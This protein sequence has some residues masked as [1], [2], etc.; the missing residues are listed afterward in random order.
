M[1]GGFQK[2]LMCV[3]GGLGDMVWAQWDELR[4]AAAV[5]GTILYIC[6]QP[7]YWVRTVRGAF[8]R[9]VVAIGVESVVLVCGMAF[10]VGIT[11]VAQLEF[12]VAEA[13]QSQMLGS[14][15]VAVV[16]R[17][18]SPVLIGIIV[19]V[20]SGSTMATELG[21]MKIGGQ[22]HVL[23]AQGISPF[24]Y[25]VV[26]RVLAAA[27]STFCLTIVFIFVAFASGYLFGATV[28]KGSR[29]LLLL[30]NSVSSA[31]RP[32][33]MLAILSK[34]IL[35]ALFTG[36]SCCIGGLSVSGSLTE[37]PQATQRALVRSI[38]GLFVISTVVSFLT[39]L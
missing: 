12:W 24:L 21:I 37:V 16:A 7:R 26:P 3:I 22:V 9:Q 32:K 29:D 13:G 30:A 6:V 18:L 34:S 1:A 25:L 20:R 38:I 2:T 27:V 36:T 17:E 39:Y 23:N 31:V 28:G 35:P 19:I 5:I 14:L 10:F 11:V 4:H 33:D 8:V 15:L